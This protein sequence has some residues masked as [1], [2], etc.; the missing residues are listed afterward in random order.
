MDFR[1]KIDFGQFMNQT[2][3]PRFEEKPDACPNCGHSPVAEI[4]YGLLD[5]TDDLRRDF[6][7]GL[8]TG[9]GCDISE[10]DPAWECKLCRWQGWKIVDEEED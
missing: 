7:A 4:L 9:G 3:H 6:E 10:D 1:C 2:E 5:D 8:V